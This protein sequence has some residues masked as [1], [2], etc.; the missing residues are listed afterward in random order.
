MVDPSK[1]ATE[2]P[3]KLQNEKIAE[4]N[5]EG[6]STEGNEHEASKTT[7]SAEEKAVVAKEEALSKSQGRAVKVLE[8][9]EKAPLEPLEADNGQPWDNRAGTDAARAAA[10]TVGP[11]QLKEEAANVSENSKIVATAT[12]DAASKIN[13]NSRAR[14]GA[15]ANSWHEYW[16]TKVVPQPTP[17]SYSSYRPLRAGEPTDEEKEAAKANG[18]S[19][20]EDKAEA[21][22]KKDDVANA[23]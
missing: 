11:A 13:V 16:V 7:E 22:A 2:D 9:A 15:L 12:A 21:D 4:A 8:A 19:E 5:K 23:K 3:I 6:T 1:S 17:D 14:E 20:K 18:P 10:A